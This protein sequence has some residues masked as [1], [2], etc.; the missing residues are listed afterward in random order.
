[1]RGR[2]F[3]GIRPTRGSIKATCPEHWKTPL[4]LFPITQ[5][6][7]T[8]SYHTCFRLWLG[9]YRSPYCMLRTRL[10]K[11]KQPAMHVLR[12]ESDPGILGI[13]SSYTVLNPST[14]HG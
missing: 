4:Q 10:Q 1:M 8:V 11:P 13:T 9:K 2:K 5:P 12:L 14:R 7:Q 6:L 3:T